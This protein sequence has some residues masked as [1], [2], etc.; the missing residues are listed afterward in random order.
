MAGRR[1]RIPRPPR[2]FEL[3]SDPD[4]GDEVVTPPILTYRNTYNPTC[5]PRSADSAESTDVSDMESI[6]SLPSNKEDSNPDLSHSEDSVHSLNSIPYLDSTHSLV[7]DDLYTSLAMDLARVGTGTERGRELREVEEGSGEGEGWRGGED[8][9]S[10]ALTRGWGDGEGRVGV[11]VGVDRQASIPDDF[12][13]TVCAQLLIDPVT[14]QCGHSFCQLCLAQTWKS[15][16]YAS[17]LALQCPVCRQPW[18]SFS[19]V[20]IQ[21]RWVGLVLVLIATG[22]IS[23]QLTFS[24][25][26]R[27]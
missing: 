17:P 15:K 9:G 21:L 1:A 6:D 25:G 13:C 7:G 18:K 5:F 24:S 20:N 8:G 16:G 23:Q 26:G 19:G 11:A 10:K 22:I 3:S 12:L 27:G 14:L 4:S 2:E